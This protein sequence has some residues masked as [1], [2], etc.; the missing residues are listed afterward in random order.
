MSSMP[1]IPK[2]Q[3]SFADHGAASVDSR[4]VLESVPSD[5]VEIDTTSP[6]LWVNPLPAPPR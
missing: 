4:T 5:G 1:K 2:E 3:R 6:T